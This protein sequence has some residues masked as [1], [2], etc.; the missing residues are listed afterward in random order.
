MR[1]R[2]RVREIIFL[3]DKLD[4][5]GHVTGQLYSVHRPDEPFLP[6]IVSGMI[7]TAERYLFYEA[8]C[9][10]GEQKEKR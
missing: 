4:D 10:R 5:T 9:R 2:I 3:A 1:E 8:D 6:G 7:R